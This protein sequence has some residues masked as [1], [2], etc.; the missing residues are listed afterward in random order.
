MGD[1][2]VPVIIAVILL[3][4]II[5]T[6]RRIKSKSCCSGGG[7]KSLVEHKTLTEPVIM[8]KIIT[9][10]G[11]HCDNCKSRIERAV[12]RLDGALCSVNLRKNTASVKLTRD[13]ADS[14]L[15]EIIEKLDF[16][17]TDIRKEK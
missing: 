10:E 3:L 16:T 14:E 9:V 4:C 2:I 11:M 12:N 7:G 13:I 1:Y 5:M 8:T 17:V 6:V 15:K